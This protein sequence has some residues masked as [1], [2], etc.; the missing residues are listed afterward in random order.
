MDI[1]DLPNDAATGVRTLP[2]VFGPSRAVAISL[3]PLLTATAVAATAQG[4]TVAA[5][6][7]PA[8]TVGLEVERVIE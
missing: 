5:S 2:V 4:P 3:A 7:E 1:K 6:L 8:S